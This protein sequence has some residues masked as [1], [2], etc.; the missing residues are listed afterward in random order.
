MSPQPSR[1]G[2]LLS[3]A[4]GA[5]AVA[6][7]A[8]DRTGT[9]ATTTETTRATTTTTTTAETT[10]VATDQTAGYPPEPTSSRPVEP[11]SVP[12]GSD[13]PA[14][15][16]DPANT[17]HAQAVT[18]VPGDAEVYW[19]FFTRGTPPVVAEGS[20]YTVEFAQ[21]RAVVARDAAT[22]RQQ[23][24]TPMTSGGSAAV[25]TVAADRVVVPT[26][27]YL[28]G[29]DR[30]DGSRRWRYDLGRGS[31]T[32]AAVVDGTAYL[33]NGSFDG[34]PAAVFAVGLDGTERW[35]VDLDDLGDDLAGANVGG[36]LAHAD[37]A[38]FVGT[39]AGVVLALD[40]ADGSERWRADVGA[41][42]RTGLSVEAGSVYAQDEAGAVHAL[43]VA[44]GSERWTGSAS[45]P[46][47]GATPSVVEAGLF[48]SGTV[49]VGGES[50]LHALSARDG[51]ERWRVV[52][53]DPVAT[54]TVAGGTVYVGATGFEDRRVRAIDLRTGDVEWSWQ[55]RQKRISD[56]VQAGVVGAP[57]P[58]RGGLYV[59]AADGLWAFG[60]PEE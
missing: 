54:P 13:W 28:Y 10:D 60:Q 52:T 32:P 33:C 11:R 16:R 39:D 30:R 31:P 36:P 21:D 37:G 9:S 15:Q 24:A 41:A 48:E 17:G 29:F 58:V 25:P 43:D 23:W 26:Y 42:I 1:R 45:R 8:G 40:A 44:D 19:Q 55:T 20:L 56:Y 3:L 14:F 59:M 57:T 12:G 18:A 50:G 2:F 7:C 22:G 27:S 51:S 49:I 38:L 35:T 46:D 5:A 34:R 47:G 4:A 53:G 6:G